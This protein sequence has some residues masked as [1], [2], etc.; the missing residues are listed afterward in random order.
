[1]F[2]INCKCKETTCALKV[3]A[4][5]VTDPLW[6]NICGYNLDMHLIPLSNELKSELKKWVLNYGKWIDLE[7]DKLIDNGFE[8]EDKH[9]EV[10]LSLTEKVRREL[11]DH[12]SI[13][14]SPSKLAR[15]YANKDKLLKEYPF[16][17]SFI[18][19]EN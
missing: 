15:S 18:K 7:T 1:M 2:K 9:N 17:A 14:F 11:G 10:G 12:Y 4:D 6:C 5:F 16:L 13:T 19:G 3:E 8:L